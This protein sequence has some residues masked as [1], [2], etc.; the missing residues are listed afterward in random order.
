MKS[1]PIQPYPHAPTK[2]DNVRHYA[3]FLDIFSW[4]HINIP[5]SEALEQMPRYAKFIKDILTKKRRLGNIEVKHTKMT[6][7]LD[8]KSIVRPSGIAEDVL[9][10]VDKFLFP[11]DFVMMDIEED[12]D[13]PLILGRS[14][15]KTAKMV[16]F[17]D[18]GLM[19]VRVQ[20]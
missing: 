8:D 15:M 1:F 18:Y 14:F 12:D 16:I 2:K 9:G 19:K 3:R 6:L 5:F 13:A 7:R 20:D 10:K 11:T 4:L 17:V